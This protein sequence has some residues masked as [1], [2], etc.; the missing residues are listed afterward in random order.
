MSNCL[1]CIQDSLAVGEMATTFSNFSHPNF[2]YT[3]FVIPR[4]KQLRATTFQTSCE[5]TED[6]VAFCWQPCVGSS[7]WF[8]Q[9]HINFPR[10]TTKT[11]IAQKWPH[12]LSWQ[13]H[14]LSGHLLYRNQNNTATNQ[15]ASFKKA[16]NQ[17]SDSIAPGVLWTE[18]KAISD[19]ERTLQATGNVG[20]L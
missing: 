20:E 18:H 2:I 13:D 9:I 17:K 11:N 7:Y 16:T 1:R 15:N 4:A 12:C 8:A 19:K 10:L 6:F 3:V 14:R 5:F